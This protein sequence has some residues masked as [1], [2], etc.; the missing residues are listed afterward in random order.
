MFS[1]F[2]YHE[3]QTKDN[4]AKEC[5]EHRQLSLLLHNCSE[6]PPDR[7]TLD[8]EV[9]ILE[10]GS[11]HL[12]FPR[13]PHPASLFLSFFFLWFVVA[14]TEKQCSILK[15]EHSFIHLQSTGLIAFTWSGS[16]GIVYYTYSI[17][18]SWS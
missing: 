5:V 2:V 13:A 3:T 8:S 12:Q 14:F 4:M 16:P 9:W 17:N 10:Y 11:P 15:Q 6:V 18:I 7:V 1:H